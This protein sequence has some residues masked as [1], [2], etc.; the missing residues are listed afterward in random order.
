VLKIELKMLVASHD[1]IRLNAI[2]KPCC[3][4]GSPHAEELGAETAEEMLRTWVAA[5]E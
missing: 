3:K 1:K 4:A 5:T 2:F